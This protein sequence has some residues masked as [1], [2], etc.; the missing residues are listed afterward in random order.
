MRTATILVAALLA[1][2]L[3]GCEDD[4]TAPRTPPPAAPRGLYSVTGDHQVTLHWLAN[5][6]SDIAGY[7]VYQAQCASGSSCPYD[8]IG[9]TTGTSFVVTGLQNGETR[10][11]AVAAYDSKG[12]ESDLTGEDVFDTP[13]PAGTDAAITNYLNGNAGSGW[14][15][16][17]AVAR[18]R[19]DTLADVYYGHNGS[20][21]EMF[22]N[23]DSTLVQDAGYATTLDAVDWAPRVGYSPT[24]TVELIIG[25]CYVVRTKDHNFAKFRVKNLSP[26]AVVFDWAYQVAPDN[27]ELRVRRAAGVSVARAFVAYR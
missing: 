27:Q 26:T 2:G 24:G 1:L 9:S 17:A 4:T 14:D 15:F 5:T 8:R 18:S 16:S 10:F 12:H 11:Y 13:R 23:A 6:E 25:H 22:S 20:I 21:A 19:A 7:R 3:A